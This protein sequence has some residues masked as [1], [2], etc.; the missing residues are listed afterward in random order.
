MNQSSLVQSCFTMKMF[1]YHTFQN[2]LI[3]NCST[4]FQGAIR[5]YQNFFKLSRKVS[6]HINCSNPLASS[7]LTTPQSPSFVISFSRRGGFY[8]RV[9]CAV[10][11]DRVSRVTTPS[12][13]AHRTATAPTCRSSYHQDEVQVRRA[14]QTKP[15]T[16]EELEMT[17][18][19]CTCSIPS[20]WIPH[21]CTLLSSRLALNWLKLS[22]MDIHSI[23]H[24]QL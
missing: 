17:N 18:S 22:L 3:I 8:P 10:W 15:Q 2:M 7:P 12:T 14:S 6:M 21:T 11:A 4:N 23:S 19:E 5:T 1:F 20:H 16:W 24:G 13:T 9:E